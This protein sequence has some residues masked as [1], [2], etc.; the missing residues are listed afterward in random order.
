[1][2]DWI[3]AKALDRWTPKQIFD[4]LDALRGDKLDKFLEEHQ[5]DALPPLYTIQ[6][7]V[8]DMTVVDTS[9]AWRMD[10]KDTK[11]EDLRLILDILTDVIE[12]SYGEKLT[13]TKAE[14]AWIVR[15]SKA[16][17]TAPSWL[18][19][20][21]VQL[22][23]LYESQGRSTKDFDIFVAYKPWEDWEAHIEWGAYSIDSR[24]FS[25]FPS[26]PYLSWLKSS[27]SARDRAADLVEMLKSGADLATMS[28]FANI[29]PWKLEEV[30]QNRPL[31]EKYVEQHRELQDADVIQATVAER[32]KHRKRTKE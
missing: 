25:L 13:L 4:Y 30:L 8:K 14:V 20:R 29:P 7:I 15:I 3:E 23:L 1:M 21:L 5:A 32:D 12:S 9:D 18:V 17:P 16:A 26:I 27:G 10:D 11:P 31:L 24:I 6:R 2:Q 28:A 22:Y 19:W